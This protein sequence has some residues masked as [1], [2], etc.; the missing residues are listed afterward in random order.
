M[1]RNNLSLS[2]LQ[3][4]FYSFPRKLLLGQLANKKDNFFL[5]VDLICEFPNTS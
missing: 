3:K 4:C 5:K 1:N 2:K